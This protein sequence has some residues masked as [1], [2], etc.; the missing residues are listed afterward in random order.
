MSNRGPKPQILDVLERLN[1][2]RQCGDSELVA[3]LDATLDRMDR[4]RGY[5]R[6]AGFMRTDDQRLPPTRR[7]VS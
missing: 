4:R 5:T 7:R 6:R 2:A 3:S 1:I